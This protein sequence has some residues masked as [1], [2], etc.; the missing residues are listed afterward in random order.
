MSLCEDKYKYTST[1]ALEIAKKYAPV[2]YFH[3]DEKYFPCD[4][5]DY[6]KY[7]KFVDKHGNADSTMKILE[8][9]DVGDLENM[10][11]NLVLNNGMEYRRGNYKLHESTKLYN[12]PALFFMVKRYNNEFTDIIYLFTYAY[13]GTYMPH[14]YDEEYCCIRLKNNKIARVYMSVHD[15]GYWYRTHQVEFTND[16]NPR[17]KLYVGLESHSVRQRAGTYFRIFGIGN[18]STSSNGK[19]WHP[20]RFIDLA[21]LPSEYIFMEH[22]GGGRA[23]DGSRTFTPKDRS[24][25][26]PML[27]NSPTLDKKL[28]K[29]AIGDL[30]YNVLMYVMLSIFILSFAMFVIILIRKN[31]ALNNPDNLIDRRLIKYSFFNKSLLGIKPYP[32]I[33]LKSAAELLLPM[34]TIFGGFSYYY[35]S[36]N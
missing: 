36:T 35:L 27:Y 11:G 9:R 6:V 16:V 17:L 1:E 13:N 19:V 25:V 28:I 12:I 21:N 22:F 10:R 14:N 8:S 31:S 18:D 29:D 5:R 7:C 24:K 20:T 23:D 32:S 15:G 34:L 33:Y 3:E 2:L 30:K 4:T 26:T